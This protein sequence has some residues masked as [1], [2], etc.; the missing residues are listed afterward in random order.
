MTLYSSVYSII[1]HHSEKV[2]LMENKITG[3]IDI[4]CCED[5][6]EMVTKLIV[7]YVLSFYNF[8]P[9]DKLLK[10]CGYCEAIL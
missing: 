8:S 1:V 5:Y 4:A 6:D 2:S 3:D 7:L 10:Y 9:T